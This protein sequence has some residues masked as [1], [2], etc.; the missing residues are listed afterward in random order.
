LL[1]AC[2]DD[3]TDDRDIIQTTTD[4][5]A[6]LAGSVSG[7]SDIVQASDGQALRR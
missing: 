1:I 6:D 4:W 5:H 2:T 7:T 3:S